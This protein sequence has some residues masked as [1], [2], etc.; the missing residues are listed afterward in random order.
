M[1]LKRKRV[2]LDHANYLKNLGI[3]LREMRRFEQGQRPEGFSEELASGID[4]GFDLLD[5]ALKQLEAQARKL[6]TG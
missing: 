6:A 3:K 5:A 4:N 2:Y 1:A